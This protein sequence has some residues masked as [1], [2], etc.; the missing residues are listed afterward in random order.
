MNAEIITTGTELLLGEI[1]DT[2]AAWLARRLRD[3]GINLYYKTT[4]GD[5]E[6]RIAAVMR[7]ALARA[8]V[9]I[10]S[11]GLGPTVDDVT[12]EAAARATGRPLQL[13]E[14]CWA[15]VQALFAR[16]G[17]QPGENN[18]RQAFLP[19]GSIPIPN[20][21]GTAPG[22]RVPVERPGQPPA[23]LVCLPGVPR[24]LKHL[25]QETVEPWLA[26]LLGPHRVWI[27][28][29]TLRT[30]GMGES[31]IDAVIADLMR[32]SNPTVGLA[33]HLG[34]VDIRVAARA[35]SEAEADAMIEAVATEVRRR[36]GHAV[37][38]E[39]DEA[40]EAV[41]ARLLLEEGHTLALLET[42]TRGEVAQRLLATPHGS[43]VVRLARVVEGTGDLSVA[44]RAPLVSAEAAAD[45][46]RW[47]LADGD[48]SLALAICGT[49]DPD[50]GPYGRYRGETHMALAWQGGA[51]QHRLDFG[52]TG[53]VSQRWA[54]NAALNRLRLWLLARR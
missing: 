13:H 38:G 1:V 54:A 11:G 33:A 20:P 26:E 43:Q 29:R 8:D 34:Q 12:R 14:A 27:K 16:W 44:L 42:N 46:A 36:L 48:A 51:E 9:V 25:M 5:N 28:A 35:A 31:A 53:E 40:L 47:L 32:G 39:G 49:L 6:E 52:G 41:V 22:F 18:R 7:Q 21:V 37:Y 30:V 45:L 15:E 17:R 23:W 24:E 3:L 4:V 19:A 2:N 50:A 10:V